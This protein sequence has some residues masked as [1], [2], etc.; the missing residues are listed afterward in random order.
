MLGDLKFMTVGN[1]D[2]TNRFHCLH[3]IY[4]DALGD[5]GTNVS[6]GGDEFMSG[7]SG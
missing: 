2:V 3:L 6:T 7:R 1:I 4:A 5:I